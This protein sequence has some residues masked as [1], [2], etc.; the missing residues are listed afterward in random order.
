MRGSDGFGFPELQTVTER[1]W[2][3]E[4]S[5]WRFQ[6]AGK[7]CSSGSFQMFCLDCVL[8]SGAEATNP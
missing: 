2:D 7:C 3:Q 4:L 8:R 6:S 5:L 1:C